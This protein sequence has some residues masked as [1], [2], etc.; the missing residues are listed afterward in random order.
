MQQLDFGW[1]DEALEPDEGD[2]Q[3]LGDGHHYYLISG[4]PVGAIWTS[5]PE[6]AVVGYRWQC[7]ADRGRER[8]LT[9]A[10]IRV[11]H[12]WRVRGP[13]WRRE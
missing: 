12:A 9:E 11:E 8:T 10:R 1:G 3:T 4:A 13:E 2:W 5:Y 7:C 6:T